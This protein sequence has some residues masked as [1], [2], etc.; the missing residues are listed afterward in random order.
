MLAALIA[1][2]VLML[3]MRL[4]NYLKRKRREKLSP[5]PD[6][7]GAPTDSQD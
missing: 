6:K 4:S 1:L 5:K 3:F 7:A 2:A